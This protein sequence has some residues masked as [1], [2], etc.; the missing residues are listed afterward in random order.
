[1][2]FAQTRQCRTIALVVALCFALPAFFT[3]QAFA[4]S[5]KDV[6]K[7]GGIFSVTGPASFLGDPEKK[8][9]QLAIEQINGGGGIDGRMLEGVIY[10]T[11]GDPSK[12]VISAGKLINKDGVTAIVGPS[13]TPTTLAVVPLVERAKLPF[14]SCAAGNK[15]VDPVKP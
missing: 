14:I 13:R 2:L 15:I 11:E 3:A 1:M 8:S 5:H 4:D 12:T 9:M 6:V 7:I 10:D